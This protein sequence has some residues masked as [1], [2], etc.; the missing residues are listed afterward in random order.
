M[1]IRNA[2]IVAGR[3]VDR[4]SG[5]EITG[6][7]SD[8]TLYFYIAERMLEERKVAAKIDATLETVVFWLACIVFGATAALVTNAV[9]FWILPPALLP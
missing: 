4:K 3:I 6:L 1:D 2:R 8:P 7:P 5:E 9:G